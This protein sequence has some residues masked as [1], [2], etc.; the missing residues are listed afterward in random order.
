MH[1]TEACFAEFDNAEHLSTENLSQVLKDFP[2]K[3][4]MVLRG[5]VHLE[6]GALCPTVGGCWSRERCRGHA[7]P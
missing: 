6:A 2:L 7:P 1:D 4:Q 3:A 5:L